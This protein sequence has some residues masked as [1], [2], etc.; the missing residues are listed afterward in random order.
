[1]R[2]LQHGHWNAHILS[3]RRAALV[4]LH[5]AASGVVLA[6]PDDLIRGGLVQAEPEGGL[7]LPH[8]TRDV[9]AAAKLVREALAVRVQHQASN[10]A[11]RLGCQELDLGV[12]VIGFH[13]ACGVNLHP[14][15]VNALS[16]DRLPHLDAITCAML[17]I[18]GW[19]VH[20]V[21]T[22]LR[23]QRLL[24]EVRAEPSGGKD[25]WPVLLEVQAAL[26]VD[27]PDDASP[28]GARQ[29]LVS[30]RLRNDP[31]LVRTLGNLLDHLDQGVSNCHAREAL[32][33][34]VRSRS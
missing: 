24:R 15:E 23:E 34:A 30:T 6:M 7:V 10:T 20:K 29:Q 2:L 11:Q 3:Q 21:R 27:Q 31:G 17:T 5:D 13:Q 18:G 8:L 12:R 22:I 33:P 19:Q 14:L 32:L 26:L 1:M 9:V 16:A 28:I 25:H 4:E